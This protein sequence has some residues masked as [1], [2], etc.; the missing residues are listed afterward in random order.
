M[1]GDPPI[2]WR[3]RRIT[4]SG[5]P[6]SSF[7]P[8][9]RAGDADGTQHDVWHRHRLHTHPLELGCPNLAIGAFHRTEHLRQIVERL[10]A[11][12]VLQYVVEEMQKRLLVPFRWKAQEIEQIEY[13]YGVNL[14]WRGRQEN[15][16]LRLIR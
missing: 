11:W 16:A 2:D 1:A 10:V 5:I 13:L 15:E 9:W 3:C 7:Q 6:I 14:H 12:I 8:A 4:L